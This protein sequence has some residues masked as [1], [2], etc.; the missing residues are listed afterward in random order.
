VQ[1]L[2]APST[3][4]FFSREGYLIGTRASLSTFLKD[5]TSIPVD[6]L[7]DQRLL[8]QFGVEERLSWAAGRLTKREEDSAYSLLGLFNIFMPPIY[9]EGKEHAMRRLRKTI[10]EAE[11]KAETDVLRSLLFEQMTSRSDNIKDAHQHTCQWLLQQP[12]YVDWMDPDLIA[13]HDGFIWIK[14]NPGAGKST[15]MRFGH[16]QA[17]QKLENSN[18]SP[19]EGTMVIAFFFNARGGLTEKSTVGMYRSLLVQ[20]MKRPS[21]KEKVRRL[22]PFPVEILSENYSWTVS[23]LQNLFAQ[24]I[25]SIK[26][27]VVCFVDALDECEEEEIR[28]MLSCWKDIGDRAASTN[29]VFQVCLAS[30]HYPHITFDRGI[31]LNLDLQSGHTQDIVEYLKTEL[32]IG[33][34]KRAVQIREGVQMKALGNFMWVVLVVA[35]L[36]KAY[37]GGRM[38]ALQKL[39][40]SLPAGLHDL[41]RDILARGTSNKNEV[42]YC[43]QWIL[44]AAEPMSPEELYFAILSGVEPDA[45]LEWDKDDVSDEDISR[46]VLNSSKGLAQITVS[47][48]PKVQFIHQSVNDFLLKGRGME[49]V[50]SNPEPDFVRMSQHRLLRCCTKYMT[51]S[52]VAQARADSTSDALKHAALDMSVLVISRYPFLPYAIRYV[53]HHANAAKQRINTEQFDYVQYTDLDLHVLHG[54]ESD[55]E[56]LEPCDD[57]TAQQQD[58]NMCMVFLSCT[59]LNLPSFCVASNTTTNSKTVRI[60]TTGQSDLGAMVVTTALSDYFNPSANGSFGSFASI[61]GTLLYASL[62]RLRQVNPETANRDEMSTLISTSERYE[63]RLLLSILVKDPLVSAVKKDSF[64]TVN[65][66]LDH[67]YYTNLRGEYYGHALHVAVRMGN[68]PMVRL[69][70]EHG[71]DTDTKGEIC[72]IALPAAAAVGTPGI[73]NILLDYG[74]DHNVR[75]EYYDTARQVASGNGRWDL[76]RLFEIRMANNR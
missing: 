49:Y 43:I 57:Y 36:N 76:V 11:E 3:L 25:L 5:I 50:L 9:G 27:P 45:D 63:N 28:G 75:R 51:K 12:N 13:Q 30:R 60:F 37:D 67:G 42:S 72:P 58:K 31:E 4:T 20:L 2:V 47:E 61:Y 16:R 41:F 59:P 8:A 17:L 64:D 33:Y 35:M 38:H 48:S 66:L 52:M 70:L 29:I 32:N 26:T 15:I 40:Q 10:Q 65:M 62:V 7:N 14:G 39:L 56:F 53:P 46:F 19:N 69:L 1:E 34:S 44:F 74:A 71:T 68:E 21:Y 6:T 55:Q 18:A 23:T 54:N 24:A 22:L 73:E